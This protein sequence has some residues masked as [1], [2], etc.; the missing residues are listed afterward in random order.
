MADGPPNKILV[1]C[2]F[3]GTPAENAIAASNA[4]QAFYD[5]YGVWPTVAVVDQNGALLIGA[6]E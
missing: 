5:E 6:Y 4:Y 3:T 1:G 2:T